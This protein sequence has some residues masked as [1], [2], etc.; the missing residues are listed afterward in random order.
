MPLCLVD[1][2]RGD[3]VLILACGF[4]V[5][6]ELLVRL[7]QLHVIVDVIFWPIVFG[8]V[9]LHSINIYSP[10]KCVFGDNLN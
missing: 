5:K 4:R 7:L 3:Q 9:T 8:L 6:L 2:I 1:H 10:L